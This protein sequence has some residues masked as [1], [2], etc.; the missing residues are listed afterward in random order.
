[1]ILPVSRQFMIYTTFIYMI[2]TYTVFLHVIFLHAELKH[3]SRC[4]KV[5]ACYLGGQEYPQMRASCMAHDILTTQLQEI[6]FC[7]IVHTFIKQEMTNCKS[8]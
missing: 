1:M 4:A 7:L 2:M 3:G 8:H 5:S 6:E